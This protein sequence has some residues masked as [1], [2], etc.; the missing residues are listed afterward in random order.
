MG[1]KRASYSKRIGSVHRNMTGILSRPAH[2]PQP[3]LCATPG[4]CRS[5]PQL[6]SNRKHKHISRSP[7]AIRHGKELTNT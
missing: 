4:R 6:H 3:L 5:S 2:N 1:V 7:S